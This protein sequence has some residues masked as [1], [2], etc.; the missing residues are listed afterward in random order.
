MIDIPIII[1]VKFDWNKIYNLFLI[2]SKIK[3]I[4]NSII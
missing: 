2:L 4:N 3:N 1:D